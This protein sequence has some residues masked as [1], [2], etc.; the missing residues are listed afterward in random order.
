[1]CNNQFE[2]F[3]ITKLYLHNRPR[4]LF[5]FVATTTT[6]TATK[7]AT[8]ATKCTSEKHFFKL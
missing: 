7:T 6:A 4:N 3:S 5:V 1:V 2:F 8:A